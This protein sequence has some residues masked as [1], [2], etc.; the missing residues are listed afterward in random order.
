MKKVIFIISS[1]V[2]FYSCN[3]KPKAEQQIAA[4]IQSNNVTL[5]EAI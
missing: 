2:F 5:T 1:I 4:D 3:N